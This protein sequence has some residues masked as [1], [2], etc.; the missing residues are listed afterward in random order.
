M[1]RI[2]AALC[3][4]GLPYKRKKERTMD[5]YYSFKFEASPVVADIFNHKVSI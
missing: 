4:G 1:P 2:G 3:A 5:T